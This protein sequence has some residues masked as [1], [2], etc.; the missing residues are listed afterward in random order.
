[1][2]IIN[3]IIHS[4]AN[5]VTG[6]FT[7]CIKNSLRE[8]RPEIRFFHLKGE[9]WDIHPKIVK[10]YILADDESMSNVSPL[11]Y[12][13]MIRFYTIRI[14]EILDMLGYTWVMRLDDDSRIFSPINYDI[15]SFMETF[16]YQYAYRIVALETP[17]FSFWDFVQSY[18]I[19]A[20][21]T[22]TRQLLDSCDQKRNI[23]DFN[24]G[25]CGQMPGYYNNFFVTNV[26]RWLEPDV[27]HLLKTIDDSGTIFMFRWTDLNFQSL[28]VRLLF[29]EN[30]VHRFTGFGYAHLSGNQ[31]YPLYGIVQTGAS[32]FCY[33]LIITGCA[34]VV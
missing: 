7:T 34:G 15:F 5:N 9:N 19:D 31:K 13:K 29:E 18:V 24:F 21:I 20:N 30:S 8:N 22:N 28:V 4:P 27:Q 11:G 25:N 16:H 14:W 33:F 12:R 6:D 17:G 2:V 32:F 1:M 26:S 3:F 10:E 23:K